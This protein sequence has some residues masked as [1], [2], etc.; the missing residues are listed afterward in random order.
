MKKISFLTFL[1][2]SHCVC[3]S[4]IS[5]KIDNCTS[6]SLTIHSFNGH[7]F[8][9][10]DKFY[11]KV[12]E[13]K[14]YFNF[15][16]DHPKFVLLNSLRIYIEPND[17]IYLTFD[18]KNYRKTVTF[19]H[20]H[21]R[22]NYFLFQESIKQRHWENLD[23]P[24]DFSDQFNEDLELLE[25]NKDFFSDSFYTLYRLD[26]QY[27][28]LH[29]AIFKGY[30]KSM[31]NKSSEEKSKWE[32]FLDDWIGSVRLN[33]SEALESREYHNYLEKYATYKI[34]FKG[35]Y[36]NQLKT[37]GLEFAKAM[38]YI[39][40]LKGKVLEYALGNLLARNEFG[41]IRNEALSSLYD[42]FKEKFPKSK[43]ISK[44][45]YVDELTEVQ[46]GKKFKAFLDGEIIT[47]DSFEYFLGQIGEKPIYIDFWATWCKPCI[48]QFKYL[49]EI[50]EKFGNLID[51]LYISID[52]MKNKD[53]VS[54][55]IERFGLK[56]HNIILSDKK[57]IQELG[58]IGIPRYMIAD[59]SGKIIDIDAPSPSN[60]RKL[61]QQLEKVLE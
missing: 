54:Q 9:T 16:I 2:I 32:P 3:G 29:S 56:G 47:Y 24:I 12:E 15:N 50:K 48:Q 8:T 7:Y 40:D 58:I 6:D 22:E 21:N 52:E 36:E 35:L 23:E 17:S 45:R 26:L 10:A 4:I 18:E 33:N 37:E 1:L 44:L 5:G 53:R 42:D 14:F 38:I 43:F 20:D 28:Y 51:Y 25:K 46:E 34:S 39:N 31:V 11:S 61:T 19:Y 49:P 13:G 41:T 55:F 59:A 27:L 60:K 30:V 57:T